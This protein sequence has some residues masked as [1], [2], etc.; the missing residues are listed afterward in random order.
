MSFGEALK[1][2]LRPDIAKGSLSRAQWAGKGHVTEL[3]TMDPNNGF[4]FHITPRPDTPRA[5]TLIHCLL[6]NDVRV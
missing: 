1:L 4:G 5:K 3:S 2:T 6:G